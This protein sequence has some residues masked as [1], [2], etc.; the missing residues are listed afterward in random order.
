MTELFINT[1]IIMIP[2]DK[3][4]SIVMMKTTDYIQEAE[5]HYEML[6]SD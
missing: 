3:G 1:I 2:A 5:R 4:G 6:N